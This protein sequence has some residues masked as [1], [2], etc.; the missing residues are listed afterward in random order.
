[1]GSRVTLVCSRRMKYRIYE[2]MEIPDIVG[3]STT[4]SLKEVLQNSTVRVLDWNDLVIGDPLGRGA[5]GVVSRGT[6]QG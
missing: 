1:M 5:F 6:Y 4:L 2:S 3:N